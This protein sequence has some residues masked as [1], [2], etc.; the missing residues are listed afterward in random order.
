MRRLLADLLAIAAGELLA[1]R[2]DHLEATRDLLQRLGH[3]LSDLR[4]PRSTAA[5]AARWSLNDD[6]LVFDVVRPWLAN[7][8]LAHEGANVLRL[9]CCGLRGKL[10]LGRRCGEF[11][12]LQFQLLE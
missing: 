4:Q 1:Y 10:V 7:R 11:F 12:E 8:P 2:L 9:R 6:A 3:I 5:G